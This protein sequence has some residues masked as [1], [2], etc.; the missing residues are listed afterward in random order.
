MADLL[1]A[2]YPPPPTVAYTPPGSVVVTHHQSIVPIIVIITITFFII[3]GY[4]IF[5]IIMSK[6]KKWI[7]GEYSPPKLANGVQPAGDIVPRSPD[8][9]DL[10][11]S[12]ICKSYSYY[13]ITPP[14]DS[15][16][17]AV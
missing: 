8:V 1:P 9:V 2:N 16:C 11:K 6:Q 7:F 14:A 3:I 4:T 5:V 13:G 12:L 15:G 17:P 10:Q